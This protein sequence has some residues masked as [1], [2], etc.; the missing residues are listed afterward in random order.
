VH[1]IVLALLT[2]MVYHEDKFGV[3]IVMLRM[4]FFW[5]RG[6][7]PNP[8]HNER[9]SINNKTRFVPKRNPPTPP[10]ASGPGDREGQ[11]LLQWDT[12]SPFTN[13]TAMFLNVISVCFFEG[14]NYLIALVRHMMTCQ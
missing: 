13:C 4:I 3:S 6:K 5:N 12:W 1:V 11:I 14:M 2:Q 7:P 9:G 10:P 8:T